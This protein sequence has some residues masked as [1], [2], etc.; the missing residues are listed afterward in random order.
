[1]GAGDPRFSVF[2]LLPALNKEARDV[3]LPPSF[4]PS[5]PTISLQA[6]LRMLLGLVKDWSFKI[7]ADKGI[8]RDD[9]SPATLKTFGSYHLG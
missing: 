8:S 5:L 3:A 2:K 4:P 9:V 1:M 6:V 7:A